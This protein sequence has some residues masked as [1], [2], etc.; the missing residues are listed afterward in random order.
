[1]IDGIVSDFI[2][3]KGFFRVFMFLL[4]WV[5]WRFCFFGGYV[6]YEVYYIVVEFIFF[7]V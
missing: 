3:V 4:G 1:M 7:V 2:V 6:S 5:V